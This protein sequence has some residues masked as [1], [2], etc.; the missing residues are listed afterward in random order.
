LRYSVNHAVV[1]LIIN[2]FTAQSDTSNLP[3]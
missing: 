3:R 1:P 2:L